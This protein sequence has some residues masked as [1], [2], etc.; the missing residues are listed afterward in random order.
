MTLSVGHAPNTTSRHNMF[1]VLFGTN[2]NSLFSVLCVY[3]VFSRIRYAQ[4]VAYNNS[5]MTDLKTWTP[6]YKAR[7]LTFQE[8][9]LDYIL[10]IDSKTSQPDSVVAIIQGQSQRR[11]TTIWSTI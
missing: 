3:A 1:I 5:E 6:A 8:N 7:Y 11:I 10:P 2:T 4:Q 9:N